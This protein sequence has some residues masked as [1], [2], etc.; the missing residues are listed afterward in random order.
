MANLDL[1][2]RLG[3]AE[4]W[5]AVVATARPDGSVHASV[6][7][8]CIL[9]DPVDGRPVIG[10]VA[11]GATR[12]LAHLRQS[13]RATVVFRSRWE[14]VAVDGPARI[15]GPDDPLEGIPPETISGLLRAVFRGV[16]GTDD[17]WD[18]WERVMATERWAAVL[19]EPARITTQGPFVP[20]GAGASSPRA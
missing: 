10:L 8:A 15:A 9:D 12:K 6:V 5:L 16:G 4:H 11:A 2:Q 14:W 18:E 7:N 3:A 20:L 19:I 1:V 17:A 13:H